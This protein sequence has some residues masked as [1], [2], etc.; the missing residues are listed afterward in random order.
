MSKILLSKG[1]NPLDHFQPSVDFILKTQ[2]E[3]GSIP[4]FTGGHLDPW[5]HAEGAMGLTIAGHYEEAVAAY[6]WSA[7]NQ[8]ENGAWW[9]KYVDGEPVMDDDP[10]YETNFIAYIATGVW[11]HFLITEDHFFLERM[12]PCVE[13]AIDYVLSHQAD[14]GTITWAIEHNGTPKPDALV[15]G[16]SSVY[17]SIECAINIAFVLRQPKPQWSTGRAALGDAMLHHPERFDQSKA[18]YSMDWFYPI[19]TGV[20]QGQQ[21]RDHIDK[22]WD[23]FIKQDMGCLCVSDEP[24][25]TVA[26]SCELTMALIAADKRDAAVEL[27]S[28]LHQ[29]RSEDGVHWTGYQYDLD[30]LWPNEQP[31]WTAGAVLLA[32]DA[33]CDATPAS[34]LFTE[35]NLLT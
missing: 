21:A 10:R 33:L 34:K 13:S 7:N 30:L 15:T 23:T 16:C 24:W 20:Y 29:F 11:H 19:L 3:D 22:H 35:V 18:R 14:N 32:A 6:N 12:W 26:E 5:D 25:V 17:K 1:D 28:W 8:L 9:A 4:W 2:C 27:F 31:T